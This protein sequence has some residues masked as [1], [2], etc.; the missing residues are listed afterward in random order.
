MRDWRQLNSF[1]H[2]VLDGGDQLH[3][4]VTFHRGMRHLYPLGWAEWVPQPA[5]TPWR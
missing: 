2:C 3:T 1:F 4:S 5:W